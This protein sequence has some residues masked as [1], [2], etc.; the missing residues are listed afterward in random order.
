M[1]Q[2]M[3]SEGTLSAATHRAREIEREISDFKRLRGRDTTKPQTHNSDQRTNIRMVETLQSSA[4]DPQKEENLV[5]C[6]LCSKKGH[7]ASVCHSKPSKPVFPTCQFCDKVRHTANKCSPL[8]VATQGELSKACQRSG[9]TGHAAENCLSANEVTSG[10]GLRI[11]QFCEKRG[12][13][14]DK[15]VSIPCRY[16]CVSGHL[17]DICFRK[18]R[19]KAQSN[20]ALPA[21][22]PNGNAAKPQCNLCQGVGP[23]VKNCGNRFPNPGTFGSTLPRQNQSG[24]N[25]S[26]LTLLM[27]RLRMT[28][29]LQLHAVIVRRRDILSETVLHDL[30]DMA[31]ASHIRE[32]TMACR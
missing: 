5:L 6:Q 24:Q 21:D 19:L 3:K 10:Q 32:T 30:P 1:K 20:N 23:I 22:D 18:P 4:T 28:V 11:R 27:P 26:Y 16:H 31:P 12:H 7:I 15:C 8:A 2:G 14:A 13:L 17:S 25:S 29:V 9:R